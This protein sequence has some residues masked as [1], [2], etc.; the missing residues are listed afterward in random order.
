MKRPKPTPGLSDVQRLVVVK[1]ECILWF[2]WQGFCNLFFSDVS[3]NLRVFAVLEVAELMWLRVYQGPSRLLVNL[4]SELD[5]LAEA[6]VWQ[7]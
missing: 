2:L 5:A 3:F 1:M 4:R 6:L 7:D